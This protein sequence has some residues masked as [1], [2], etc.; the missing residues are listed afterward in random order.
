MSNQK[1][2]NIFNIN[3]FYCTH[4]TLIFFNLCLNGGYG[5]TGEF[6]S[7]YIANRM[8]KKL[9]VGSMVELSCGDLATGDQQVDS[10]FNFYDTCDDVTTP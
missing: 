3:L 4:Y 10:H 6:L 9:L 8:L 7:L 1:F 5:I 2:D